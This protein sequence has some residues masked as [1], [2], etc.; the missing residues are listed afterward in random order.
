MMTPALRLAGQQWEPFSCFINCEGQSHKTVSTNHKPGFWRERRVETVSNR[1]PRPQCLPQYQ[2]NALPLGQQPA[3]LIITVF[4][5]CS[6]NDATNVL[7]DL[8]IYAEKIAENMIATVFSSSYSLHFQS[9]S[10]LFF[11]F[12]FDFCKTIVLDALR[13]P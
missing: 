2:H 13:L 4:R 11:L 8:D 3:Q 1:G 12:S 5:R 7:N 10:F 9:R 6:D